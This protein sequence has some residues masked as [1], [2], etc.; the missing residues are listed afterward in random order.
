MKIGIIGTGRMGCGLGRLWAE[1]GH[2]ICFGSREPE[3]GEA[4]ALAFGEEIL[5]GSIAA[6]A[7][8]GEVLLFSV[9]WR[10]V[11]ETLPHLAP[12]EGKVVIDCTNPIPYG[13]QGLEIGH[14]DSSAEYIQRGLPKD[15]VVKAFNTIYFEN[16][17]QR[18]KN[19]RRTLFHCGDD[20]GAKHLV[21]SLGRELGFD[22]VDA[23]PLVNARLLEP[24]A[25]LW[26]QLAFPLGF[27]P[28]VAID[29]TR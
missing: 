26:I 9:P 4:I 28:D 2:E 13:G 18:G 7:E 20:E 12:F 3:K 17:D 21:A 6:A 15:Y 22:P 23:G 24:L 10:G 16:L 5:G 29:L 27:G 8:F 1:C 14:T 19:G 11:E 25:Y